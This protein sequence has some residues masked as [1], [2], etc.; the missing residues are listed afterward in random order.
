M[1]INLRRVKTMDEMRAL[2]VD[3]GSLECHALDRESVCELLE[4]VLGTFG[5]PRMSRA[6]KGVVRRFLLV[7]T[8][9]SE[10]QL[11]RRVAQYLETGRVRDLRASNSGRPF[12]RVYAR[13]DILLLVVADIAFGR[14][15]GKAMAHVFHRAFNEFGAGEYERLAGISPSHIYNLRRSR[16]YRSKHT[17]LDHT[18]PAASTIGERRAPDPKG[19]PGYLRVDTVHQGDLNR[20]KGVYIINAVDAVTQYE[21]VGAVSAISENHMIPVLRDLLALFPFVVNGFHADNGT[22][23]INHRVAAMLAKLDAEFTRS[24]PRHSND[25]GLVESKNAHVVRTHLGHEH[26]EGRA[27]RARPRLHPRHPLA[28]PELPPPLPVPGAA[29]RREG[30]DQAPLSGRPRRHAI[31]GAQAPAPR[32]AIP[33]AGRH[34]RAARRRCARRDRHRGRRAGHTRTRRTL[35]EALLRQG[36]LNPRSGT[37]WCSAPLATPGPPGAGHHA[38]AALRFAP[39]HAFH[40][41]TTAQCS[42]QNR[43]ILL[44]HHRIFLCRNRRGRQFHAPASAESATIPRHF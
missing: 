9:L 23:Y 13:A 27:R 25:N 11:D 10:A 16:T 5:Y 38:W 37:A 18:R 3:G 29:H 35:Q 36:R 2:A 17:T 42:R 40:S 8:G 19:E 34:L 41:G 1:D 26:I 15:S 6:D 39:P 7:F 31:R 21:F 24:R 14:M 28:L 22:E 33:E 4:W 32:G 20:V 30:E 43:T 44:I 12:E